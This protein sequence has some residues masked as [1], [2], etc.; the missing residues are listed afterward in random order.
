MPAC[1]SIRSIRP[2]GLT[3]VAG[4]PFQTLNDTAA[5]GAG[6][7]GSG[8]GTTFAVTFLAT[9]G[10]GYASNGDD[11]MGDPNN[12]VLQFTV[13]PT[14]GAPSV[15][16]G[17]F[18]AAACQWPGPV[19]IDPSGQF[20]YVTAA[21]S[22]GEAI[23][24]FQ[25]D[26]TT[27]ALTPVPGSPFSAAG[28]PANSASGPPLTIDPTGRFLYFPPSVSVAE[29]LAFTI[30]PTTGALTPIAGSPFTTASAPTSM[31]IAPGGQ[32]AYVT[33][34]SGSGYAVYTYAINATTGALTATG[35]SPVPAV[36]IAPPQIDPSGHFAYI[37]APVGPTGEASSQT[38]VYAYT[39]NADTGA[40]TQV[41]G[42]PYATSA[43]PG[44]PT[45]ITVVN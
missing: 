3:A 34:A 18:V 31:S 37:L 5:A 14:T 12:A 13:D 39:I 43:V 10:Y 4:S 29:I 44:S 26:A 11:A 33:Q 6:C 23:F 41:P 25:I 2:R 22:T 35:A 17:G 45:A 8:N 38:G 36:N 24:A 32:F 7:W 15:V 30:D 1:M 9:G 28:A 40:L 20:A 19:T 21:A 16:P 27:G 42:S